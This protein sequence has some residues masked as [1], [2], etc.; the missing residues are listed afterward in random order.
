MDSHRNHEQSHEHMKKVAA[1][2]WQDKRK[3]TWEY[4]QASS[5][6]DD[7]DRVKKHNSFKHST[8]IYH[9]YKAAT[10]YT[11]YV[12]HYICNLVIL[13]NNPENSI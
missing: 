12:K 9:Y 13:H 3:N 2:E 8:S 11:K 1:R 7:S 5:K 10:I 4:N 6:Q